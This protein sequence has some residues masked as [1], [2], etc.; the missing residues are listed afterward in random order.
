MEMIPT[1]MI[2]ILIGVG[3][4]FVAVFVWMFFEDTPSP[5]EWQNNYVPEEIYRNRKDEVLQYLDNEVRGDMRYEQSIIRGRQ[6]LYEPTLKG[7]VDMIEKHLGISTEV[8][9]EVE[10]KLVIKKGKK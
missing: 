6:P 3:I 4:L 1:I 2:W 5:N 7:R 9:P 8:K 10:A